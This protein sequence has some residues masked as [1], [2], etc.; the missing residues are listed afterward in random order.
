MLFGIVLAVVATAA[1][2]AAD[3]ARDTSGPYVLY[4]GQRYPADRARTFP[5]CHDGAYPEIRCFDSESERDTDM[6]QNVGSR[7][8]RAESG[9]SAR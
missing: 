9:S 8:L 3:R 1:A 6:S 5:A 4:R 7:K 2:C